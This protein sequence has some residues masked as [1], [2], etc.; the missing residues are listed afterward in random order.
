MMLATLIYF[1]ESFHKVYWQAWAGWFVY[2]PIPS[3]IPTPVL[4]IP[5]YNWRKPMLV[6]LAI[7]FI[8]QIIFPWRFALYPGK[9][10]L[11]RAGLPRFPGG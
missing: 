4:Y 9:T 8:I 11:D 1:P 3:A 10:V 6:I 5:A 2:F 7:Q